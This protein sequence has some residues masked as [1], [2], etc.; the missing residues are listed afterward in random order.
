MNP[1]KSKLVYNSIFFC[2]ISKV[3]Y[4]R[5]NILPMYEKLAYWHLMSMAFLAI[6][7]KTEFSINILL[8]TI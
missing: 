7:Q 6:E 2:S 4:D 8:Y 1:I 5:S 3:L